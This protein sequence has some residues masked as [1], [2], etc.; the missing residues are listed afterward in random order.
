MRQPSAQGLEPH[1]YRRRRLQ[2]NALACCSRG[3]QAPCFLPKTVLMQC[4]LCFLQH[5][6]DWQTTLFSV[7]PRMLRGRIRNQSWNSV[8]ENEEFLLD[9]GLKRTRKL[10]SEWAAG[11]DRRNDADILFFQS[12]LFIRAYGIR[13]ALVQGSSS[14]STGKIRRGPVHVSKISLLRC[15]NLS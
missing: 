12:K 6:S 2:A 15:L 3:L 7:Q 4:F 9:T 5:L 11:L 10:G 13:G 1:C 8:K 14:M